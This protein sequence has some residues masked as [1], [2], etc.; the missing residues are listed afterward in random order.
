MFQ[1]QHDVDPEEKRVCFDCWMKVKSF[2]EFYLM[3]E[4]FHTKCVS[5]VKVEAELVAFEEKGDE[6]IIVVDGLIQSTDAMVALDIDA[7]KSQTVIDDKIDLTE[8]KIKAHGKVTKSRPKRERENELYSKP[9]SKIQ[10]KTDSKLQKNQKHKVNTSNT[11]KRTCKT[12]KVSTQPR[13]ENAKLNSTEPV[14][15][16]KIGRPKNPERY[17]EQIV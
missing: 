16:R 14:A 6:N 13:L 5:E 7:F 4:A 15:K 1:L 9:D 3:V 2:H 17:I 11:P 10:N 12:I 8:G